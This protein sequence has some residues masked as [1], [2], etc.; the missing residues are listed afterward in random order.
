MGIYVSV[1]EVKGKAIDERIERAGW[2]DTD[3]EKS[4]N[5][6]ESYIEA[7]FIRLGYTR[8][9]LKQAPLLKTLIINYARYCI[10][11]DIFTNIAPSIAGGEEYIKWR[12]E[13]ERILTLI[14]ENKE[15]LVDGQGQLINPVGIDN[16]YEIISTTKD[17]KRSITMAPSYEWQIDD[18]YWSENAIGKR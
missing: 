17:V 3:V 8:N 18:S 9:Q 14:E 10:L 15:R 11:R 4:I 5:E 7:R 2:I 1:S 13:V 6:A 12:D 16:R